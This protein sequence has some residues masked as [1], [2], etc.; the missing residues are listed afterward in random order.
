MTT[1]I[2]DQSDP[3]SWQRALDRACLAGRVSDH[4]SP[5]TA[6][7][8]PGGGRTLP[9]VPLCSRAGEVHL[10]QG[11]GPDHVDPGTPMEA[12]HHVG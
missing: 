6:A 1:Y 12:R 5:D 10:Q 3:G 2:D 11:R 9:G 4:G 7:L 8:P